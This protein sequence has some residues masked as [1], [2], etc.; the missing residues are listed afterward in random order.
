MAIFHSNSYLL[1]GKWSTVAKLLCGY[2]IGEA[3]HA[4]TLDFLLHG[5]ISEEGNYSRAFGVIEMELAFLY[6]FLYT[7]FDTESYRYNGWA[8]F[9]V[10]VTVTILN[11]ISGAFSRRYHRSSLEQRVHGIDVTLWVTIVL[12]IIV[13]V[14]FL[15]PGIAG[16]NGRWDIVE[17][18]HAYQ[19][20]RSEK[21]MPWTSSVKREVK[22]SWQRALGQCS[23]LLY[24]DYHPWNVLPLLSLGLVD[25]TREGQKAGKRIMLTDE[26]IERVL[27]GFK[28][29]NGQLQEGQSAL[30]RN[31]LGNQFSWACTLPT[32]IHKILVWHIGTSIAMDGHPAPPTGDHRIAK[33]LSDYCA[34]LVAFVPDMLPGHG[35][36]TQ[37]IFDAV[38]MEAREQLTGCD[39]MSSRCEKLMTSN[40]GCT[41]LELAGR[42][43]RELR[44][45]VPE[46][47]RWKV[48]ADFWAEFILFLAPSNNVEIHT[49]KL[50]TGG[51][52]MTHLW[53]LLTHAGI[54]ERPSTTDGAGG[55]S[56]AP[57]HEFPV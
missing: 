50:A 56:G 3:G 45:L 48:L 55:N 12:L 16:T 35:Y 2:Q 31:Q 28:E 30:A 37:R 34:Y 42:L 11:S 43:G 9:F 32:H 51:E 15:I 22:K 41:I 7:R 1:R 39:T 33:T 46:E 25:A 29:R 36:D 18:L 47:R 20:P 57:A 10:V 52:F 21:A 6:D 40:S 26:L 38:V 23:L 24:F 17:E 44:G 53:A 4:K 8:F 5:L 49:E 14:L 19:R 54:L 13:L 27:S